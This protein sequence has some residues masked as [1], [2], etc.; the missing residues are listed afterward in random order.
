MVIKKK[1]SKEPGIQGDIDDAALRVINRGGKVSAEGP[2]DSENKDI[3][4]TMR[5]PR[6]LLKKVDAA[7]QTHV[8]K[9]SRNQFIIE[10]LHKHL[11]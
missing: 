2:P 3:R 10:M 1:L 11:K 7:R 8:G 5:L 4:F 6:G 9:V